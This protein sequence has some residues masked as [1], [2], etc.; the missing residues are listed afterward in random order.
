[1]EHR[2]IIHCLLG[3]MGLVHGILAI[4]AIRTLWSR[5]AT[6]LETWYNYKFQQVVT[7]PLKEKGTTP[8]E[9]AE[10]L[11]R[12]KRLKELYDELKTF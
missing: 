3:G 7:N 9:A 12:A 5:Q 1:M 11:A 6:D 4:L 2:F 10:I 8:E